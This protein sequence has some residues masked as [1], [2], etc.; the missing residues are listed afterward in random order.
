M[1]DTEPTAAAGGP[2]PA[3]PVAKDFHPSNPMK[4]LLATYNRTAGQTL[5]GPANSSLEHGPPPSLAGATLAKVYAKSVNEEASFR[6]AAYKLPPDVEL[7]RTSAADEEEVISVDESHDRRRRPSSSS[8]SG[9]DRLIVDAGEPF[10][11]G[12][13]TLSR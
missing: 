7:S 10:A 9:K 1:A 11:N 13:V 4:R 2:S 5:T 12:R 8:S 6:A 3:S